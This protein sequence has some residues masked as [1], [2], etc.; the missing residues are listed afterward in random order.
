MITRILAWLRS[1]WAR[2]DKGM[3][4]SGSETDQQAEDRQI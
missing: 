2:L 3:P 4:Y 1:L